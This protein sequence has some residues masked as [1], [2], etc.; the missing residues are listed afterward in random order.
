MLKFQ[1]QLL[2]K[3]G[4]AIAFIL[5][6]QWFNENQYERRSTCSGWNRPWWTDGL[7]FVTLW[8]CST[9]GNPTFCS[10]TVASRSC[11]DCSAKPADGIFARYF[12]CE[13][14]RTRIHVCD[15]AGMPIHHMQWK[16]AG[17][18]RKNWS[19]NKIRNLSYGVT[20][21]SNS[22]YRIP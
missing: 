22:F 10:P 6:Q 21:V 15:P 2:H 8:T 5:S 11:R 19:G 17:N 4:N 3:I 7:C 20:A 1:R 13:T 18:T 12:G 16:Y 14:S 9:A